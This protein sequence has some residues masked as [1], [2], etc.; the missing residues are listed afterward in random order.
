EQRYAS[1]REMYFDLK[2]LDQELKLH[3]KLKELSPAV[4][5]REPSLI[6]NRRRAIWLGGTAVAALSVLTVSRFWP[7]TSLQRL[8]V[9]PFRNTE[10]V[11]EAEPICTR[12]TA[13]LISALAETPWLDVP[14]QS[15]VSSFKGKDVDPH[16]AGRKLDASFILTG[17]VQFENK[18]P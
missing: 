12:L 15:A 3:A 6:M 7:T 2:Q 13:E 9:L 11:A 18:R 4:T 1:A 16:D 17:D 10:N 5:S 14:S 8:A